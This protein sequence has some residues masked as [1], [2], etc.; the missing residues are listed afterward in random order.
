M[1]LETFAMLFVSFI[2]FYFLLL[3][4]I[5]IAVRRVRRKFYELRLMNDAPP[6]VRSALIDEAHETKRMIIGR[7]KALGYRDDESG[8][9]HVSFERASITMDRFYFKISIRKLPDGLRLSQLLSEAN[10]LEVAVAVQRQITTYI[11]PQSGAWV[12]VC[13][14][15]YE[16]QP[17]SYKPYLDIYPPKQK[18]NMKWPARDTQHLTDEFVFDDEL[19]DGIEPADPL[20]ADE[21]KEL[22][23]A[24][25]RRLSVSIAQKQGEFS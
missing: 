17:E 3:V 4:L 7:F 24:T 16:D 14:P 11:T 12:V 1:S 21:I 25:G 6:A 18:W 23:G 8:D 15:G 2:V 22:G 20:H 5:M 9:A 13:R 19:P 10:L